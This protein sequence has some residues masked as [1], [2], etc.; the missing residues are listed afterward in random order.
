MKILL[1]YTI[2]KD[3]NKSINANANGEFE[4]RRLPYTR[5]LKSE[6]SEYAAKIISIV[7][8]HNPDSA[9]INPLFGALLAKEPDIALL[10]LRYG[11]N[12]ERLRAEQLKG[13]LMLTISNF[14]LNVKILSKTNQEL[15]VHVVENA[16][17]S[18]LRYFNK[19]RNDKQMNQKIA[20]FLD[21]INSNKVFAAAVDGL[22]L[23]VDITKIK[24]AYDLFNKVLSKRVSKL[25]KRPK[26]STK[27][28][29]KELFYTIDNLFKGVE[30]AQVISTITA[31]EGANQAD[32]T[33]LINELRQLSDMYY[34]SFSIRK[35][36]NKRKHEK[37]QV[38]DADLDE[39]TVGSENSLEEKTI[40]E[41]KATAISSDNNNGKYHPSKMYV[42]SIKKI[43]IPLSKTSTINLNG[44]SP[45]YNPTCSVNSGNHAK[46]LSKRKVLLEIGQPC[47]SV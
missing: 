31:T 7:E 44:Y 5:M 19:C 37:K 10:R 38:E 41:E 12:L 47:S 32:F 22:N 6:M 17:D 40:T 21:L 25:A 16:I 4:I 1:W 39:S 28:I 20:G 9:I 13:V 11:V 43:E 23:M 33:P 36:N 30:L 46:A 15:D 42:A 2:L 45:P 26:I 14:K 29:I 8:K 18:Y 3:M 27:N 34:K 35:A 24:E